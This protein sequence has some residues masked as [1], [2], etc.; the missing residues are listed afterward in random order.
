MKS[1]QSP[2][3]DPAAVMNRPKQARSSA[4]LVRLIRK[5][6][7]QSHLWYQTMRVCHVG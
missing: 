7:G 4:K 5:D 6:Y 3:H 2:I 1:D